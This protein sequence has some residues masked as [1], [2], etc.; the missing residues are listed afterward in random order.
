METIKAVCLFSGGLDSILAVKILEAQGIEVQAVT[1]ISPFFGNEYLGDPSPFVKRVSKAWQINLRVIDI[2]DA[3]FPILKSPPHGYGK[4]LNPCIDCKILMLKKAKTLMEETGARFIA[5]GEVIGQRPMS[6]RRDTMRIVERDSGLE[7]FLLR[8]LS[9]KLLPVTVPEREGWVDRNRLLD[10]SGR[11]RTR[12]I[13]LARELKIETYP[14][15]AG[16]CILTDE[17]LSK[18]IEYVLQGQAGAEE[19][20]LCRV[21]RHFVWPEGDHLIVAR[22]QSENALLEPLGRPGWQWLKVK[23]FPGPL[24]L[25]ISSGENPARV[26]HAAE[27]V[28]RY[29]KARHE[30]TVDVA[31]KEIATGEEKILRVSPRWELEGTGCSRI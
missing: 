19:I 29:S 31:I 21:G 14:S 1:F 6:Q 30:T 27:I 22:N 13:A 8:P 25:Y 10:L 20:F 3:Y 23:D 11:S 26:V 24:G 5:T 4:N 12:Q 16:G 17:V 28:S 7:G 15:P 18:R 9:A 2:T